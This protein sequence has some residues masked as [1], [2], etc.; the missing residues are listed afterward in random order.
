MVSVLPAGC[1]AVSGGNFGF[2]DQSCAN[3]LSLFVRDLQGNKEEQNR[4]VKHSLNAFCLAS[5]SSS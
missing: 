1:G 2:G 4:V 5:T 3:R